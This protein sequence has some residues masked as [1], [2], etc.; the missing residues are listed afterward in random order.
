MAEAARIHPVP[1]K[2][3]AGL[4]F[5]DAVVAPLTLFLLPPSGI[6]LLPPYLGLY[7]FIGLICMGGL[8]FMKRWSILSYIGLV[9]VNNMVMLKMGAWNP[10]NIALSS[11]VILIGLIYFSKM[12]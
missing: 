9:G 12:E 11:I 7:A 8:W 3:A 5:L 1:L 10:S 4:C 6:T 2:I